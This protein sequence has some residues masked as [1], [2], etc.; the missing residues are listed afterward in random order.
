MLQTFA[1]TCGYSSNT[2]TIYAEETI[3]LVQFS[4]PEN[5]LDK[6]YY[7]WT[8]AENTLRDK[9]PAMGTKKTFKLPSGETV[10]GTLVDKELRQIS[11]VSFE[12]KETSSTLFQISKHLMIFQSQ[13][14]YLDYLTANEADNPNCLL[15]IKMS[16]F[17]PFFS[18]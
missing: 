18:S 2:E 16:N 5:V 17:F 1:L 11:K 14:D 15:D 10:I 7:L 13:N 12:L 8:V 6:D 3:F 4:L 9:L